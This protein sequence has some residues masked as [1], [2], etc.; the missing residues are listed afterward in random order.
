[1]STTSAGG[2]ELVDTPDAL[3]Q[4]IA[5][6][7]GVPQYAL[8]TEFHRERTY[9]PKLALV[10]IAWRGGL[11]L[12]DPLA[13]DLSP[14]TH[15]LRSASTA[16]IHAA[17]Q[18]LEVLE[19]ACGTVPTALFDTQIAAG[20]VGM[21]SPSLA[22][23]YDRSLGVRVPK[24]DR[25]SDWL[26]RPLSATQL[27]Y[28]ASDVAHLLDVYDKLVDEL[29]H[30]GRLAWATD[31]CEH[32]RLRARGA[33]DPGEAWRRIKEARQLKGKS[34]AVVRAV[35]AWREQRAAELD[36]PPR[37]VMPDLAVVT[38]AQRPPRSA[39]ELHKM[40]GLDDR[41]LRGKQADELLAAVR[42]AL[43]Q[44]PEPRNDQPPRD[45]DRELRPAVG[46]V[47]AWVSQ[48]ARNLEIDTTLLA[49]RADLESFLRGDADA[50]LSQG[51]RAGL[52]GEP[53]RRLVE[54]EAALA[55]NGKGELVLEE[56][57]HHP[58]V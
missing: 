8:D 18:D 53:V 5:Q 36:V 11:A 43:D 48:L 38:I 6:L 32:V 44:P 3:D 4:V 49:T 29:D 26:A 13:V 9:Y 31:E 57:S 51:W 10:Q 55:F 54:G 52:V 2:H 14:L 39:N 25:L 40:R 46:L 50:R 12:I 47:S 56:R 33:R 45:L 1:M 17:D 7:E 58:I 41:H 20:F 16:V 28:A 27:E 22:T 19:L 24:A 35:A 23:L 15:I 37:Y 30:R 42:A 34:H 21:S